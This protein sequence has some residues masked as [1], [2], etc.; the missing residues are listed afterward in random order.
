MAKVIETEINIDAT[1]AL[2]WKHLTDWG[3]YSEWNPFIRRIEGNLV[4][5]SRL[6][7][8]VEPEGGKAMDFTP[9][10]LKASENSEL[11]WLGRLLI[12]GIFNGEHSF[13]LE[14]SSGQ[15]I[16]RHCERFSGLLIP[17]MWNSFGPGTIEG[18]KQ[19]N[20]ALKA[21]VESDEG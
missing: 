3:R 10:V 7:I 11:R 17:L 21:R 4:E 15:T 8:T 20:E 16:F 2:V 19:M 1:P 14:E 9:T 12:P 6:S 13:V 5:G 18:F